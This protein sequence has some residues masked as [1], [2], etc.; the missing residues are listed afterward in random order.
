MITKSRFS[1]NNVKNNSKVLN[2]SRL[3]CLQIGFNDCFYM[4]KLFY[5][6]IRCQYCDN[7]KQISHYNEI[8]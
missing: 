3:L 6:S 1:R 8:I 7:P 2:V 5:S 4:N